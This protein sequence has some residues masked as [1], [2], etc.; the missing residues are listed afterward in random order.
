MQA[1]IPDIIFIDPN[2]Q[3]SALAKRVLKKFPRT[4][5][6]IIADKSLIKT[7][8][9]H[10]VAKKQLYITNY[11]GKPIKNCQGM[12]DYVCCLYYTIALVSDCHLECTY[13]ILQD[14]LFNNPVITLYANVD[15]ILEAISK[16]SKEHPEKTI[17]VGTGELSDSLA[18]DHITEYSKDLISFAHEH[19]NVVI[20]FKSKTANIAGLLK[21]D[22]PKNVVVSWSINPQ[23]FIRQEEHKTSPL[24]ERLAAAKQCSDHGYR[25]AFHLDPLLHLENWQ[26]EYEGLIKKLR[27]DFNDDEIAWL[28]VGS[29]RFTPGLKKVME[30]RFPNS[31]LLA[32]ELYPS[33]DGKIRYF[34]PLREQMYQHV[35]G[36]LK[37]HFKQTPHYLCMETKTVWENVYG[38]TPESNTALEAHL[39]KGVTGPSEQASKPKTSTNTA[40]EQGFAV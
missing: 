15:E 35:V 36:L 2:A 18:L 10:S 22:A 23:K 32:G 39:A 37:Q 29:L 38:N 17:R 4:E 26:N 16:K 8:Q 33:A 7:S 24:A 31:K 11:K 13:C 30:E 21:E 14:Y 19:P 27:E 1:F 6:Q 3:N 20:E 40:V 25:I 28:S 9:A 34:R 5:T 12:G